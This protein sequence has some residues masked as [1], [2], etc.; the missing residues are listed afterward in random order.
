MAAQCTPYAVI[1]HTTSS[2]FVARI[3]RGGG[4]GARA[5]SEHETY[6]C[7]DSVDEQNG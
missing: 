7:R 1:S 4:G 6:T 5:G 2:S 3:G